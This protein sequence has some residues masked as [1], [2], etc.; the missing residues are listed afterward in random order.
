MRLKLTDQPVAYSAAFKAVLA[1][2]VILGAVTL[3]G[4]QV[5]AAS[6]AFDAVLGVFVFA[7]VVPTKK[8][9]ANVQSAAT[10]ARHKALAD[11]ASLQPKPRRPAKK[12]PAT[13]R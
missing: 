6:V 11:V 2:A 5:A 12:A 4:E 1:L 10:S 3:T 8:A 9:E 13:R 7:A